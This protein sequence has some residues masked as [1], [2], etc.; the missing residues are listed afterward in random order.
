M[1]DKFDNVLDAALRRQARPREGDR[2][3]AERVLRRLNGPLPRQKLPFWRLPALLLNW[4][5][6]PAWPRMAALAGCLA[7]GFAFGMTGLGQPL[8]RLGGLT[9]GSDLDSAVLAPEPLTGA[10]P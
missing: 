4:E 1:T 7:L 5:F 9:T 3:A 2:A 10:L 6:S 8:D